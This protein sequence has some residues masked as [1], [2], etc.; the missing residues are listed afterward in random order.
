L[1]IAKETDSGVPEHTATTGI[2]RQPTGQGHSADLHRPN[3]LG[4]LFAAL[5]TA[6]QRRQSGKASDQINPESA[7]ESTGIARATRRLHRAA[8]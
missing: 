2:D 8:A 1:S 4:L 7:A 5:S 3:V 6:T